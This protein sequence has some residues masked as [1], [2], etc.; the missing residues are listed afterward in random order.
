MN[1]ISNQDWK[2]QS[3]SEIPWEK[4]PTLLS[5]HL[6]ENKCFTVAR[7]IWDVLKYMLR[8][9][10]IRSGWFLNSTRISRA[11][12]ISLDNF[13][14]DLLRN[15]DLMLI[16]EKDIRGGIRHE[17]KCYAKAN[18][19]YMKE[20]QNSDEKRWK[21]HLCSVFG[22][23][24]IFTAEQCSKNSQGWWVDDF[25]SPPE[26]MRIRKVEKLVTNLN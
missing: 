7:C 21:E 19:K 16:F 4:D 13:M 9:L 17:V 20:Q 8:T 14:I 26:K 24:N 25:T 18:K 3:K 23:K 1:R 15:I 10:Q 5:R 2:I 6:L 12:E 22:C 11:D